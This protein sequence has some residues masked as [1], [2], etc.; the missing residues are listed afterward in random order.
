MKI[1]SAKVTNHM[2]L[3]LFLR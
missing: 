3:V 2:Q 1:D